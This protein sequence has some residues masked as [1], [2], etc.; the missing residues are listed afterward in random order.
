[1][2]EAAKSGG[3]YAELV[4]FLV[5]ARKKVKDAKV[6]GEL[7]YAYAKTGEASRAK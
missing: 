3:Q 6:D 1:V 7:L 4:K 5:M 2:I